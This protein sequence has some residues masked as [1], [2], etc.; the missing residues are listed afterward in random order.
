MSSRFYNGTKMLEMVGALH[1][2]MAIGTQSEMCC[3]NETGSYQDS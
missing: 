3:G 2:G 1:L